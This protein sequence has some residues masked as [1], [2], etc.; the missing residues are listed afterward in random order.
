M[1]SRDGDSIYMLDLSSLLAI[2][3][4]YV[5]RLGLQPRP[6]ILWAIHGLSQM[7][8]ED[9]LPEWRPPLS[10]QKSEETICHIL[11]YAVKSC[12]L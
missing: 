7:S 9:C 3:G 4:S 8:R 10:N 5:E 11:F 2:W 12:V 1:T 6:G